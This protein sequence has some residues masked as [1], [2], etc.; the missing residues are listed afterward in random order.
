MKHLKEESETLRDLLYNFTLWLF[1]DSVPV[2][3]FFELERTDYGAK[4]GIPWK[5]MVGHFI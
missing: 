4:Y 1:R 2:V 3:C 5:H